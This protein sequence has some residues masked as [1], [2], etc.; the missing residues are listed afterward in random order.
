M[1]LGQTLLCMRKACCFGR[2]AGTP[3]TRMQSLACIVANVIK[4]VPAVSHCFTSGCPLL[5]FH[6]HFSSLPSLLIPYTEIL[7]CSATA[8]TVLNTLNS[9][10]LFPILSIKWQKMMKRIGATIQNSV[11]KKEHIHL[12]IATVWHFCLI[13]DFKDG[14]EDFSHFTSKKWTIKCWI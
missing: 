6:L 12:K 13:T 7:S 10:F 1:S 11:S 9:F 8:L 2:K 3:S 4:S 5:C 14:N